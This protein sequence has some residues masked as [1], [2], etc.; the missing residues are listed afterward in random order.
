M[1]HGVECM[2]VIIP[3]FVSHLSHI[4]LDL[5]NRKGV[6]LFYPSKYRLCFGI[7]ESNGKVNKFLFILFSLLIVLYLILISMGVFDFFLK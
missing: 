7:C 4:V 6:A 3:Y 2:N 1:L 5:F